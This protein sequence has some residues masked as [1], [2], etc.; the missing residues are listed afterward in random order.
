MELVNY[1]LHSVSATENRRRQ[2]KKVFLSSVTSPR[3][4]HL[5]FLVGLH[6]NIVLEM[7]AAYFKSDAQEG[8]GIVDVFDYLPSHGVA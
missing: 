5:R 8:I 7:I 6:S 2:S 1:G 3:G 4:P